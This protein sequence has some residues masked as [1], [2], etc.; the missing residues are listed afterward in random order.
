MTITVSNIKDYL[1]FISFIVF[2]TFGTMISFNSMELAET[3]TN[4]PMILFCYACVLFLIMP[5]HKPLIKNPLKNSFYLLCICVCISS[6]F[7]PSHEL[8]YGIFLLIT[9][10]LFNLFYWGNFK[11][12]Y[13]IITIAYLGSNIICLYNYGISSFNSQGVIY[14]FGGVLLLNLLCIRKVSNIIVFALV[15]LLEVFLLSL[16]KSRTSMLFFLITV[17][18]T[19]SYLFKREKS[20]IKLLLFIA[21]ILSYQFILTFFNEIFFQK[22]GGDD[23]TSNRLNI[24]MGILSRLS[25][26]GNGTTY[27][28]DFDAHNSFMQILEIFGI[29]SL[30]AFIYFVLRIIP[31]I[32]SSQYYI[33]YFN[34]FISWVGISMFENLDPFTTRLVPISVLLFFHIS[35]LSYDS[36]KFNTL[37][38]KHK[39]GK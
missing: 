2:F 28:Y 37:T 32:R 11:K 24:W 6:L 4:K 23:I 10:S 19:Y 27:M 30:M 18:V 20:Y 22:W 33:I 14:V 12:S 16:T 9:L 1:L 36:T 38:V 25:F 8:L 15:V 21:A 13:T 26:F 39:N 3:I 31:A 34:F 29:F 17:I 7:N 5:K 35:L